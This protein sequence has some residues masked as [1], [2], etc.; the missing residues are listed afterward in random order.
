MA[1]EQTLTVA[2]MLRTTAQNT[3]ELLNKVADHV[4]KIENEN[5]EMKRKLHD[6][7]K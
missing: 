3:F 6:D 4:E 1:E 2:Q 5:A 7:L